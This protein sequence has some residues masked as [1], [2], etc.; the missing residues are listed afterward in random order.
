MLRVATNFY[1]ELFKKEDTPNIRLKDHFFSPREKITPGENLE[2]ERR[3]TKVRLEK[4]SLVLMLKEHKVLMAY[5]SYFFQKFWK[6]IK[7]DLM[8]HFYDW[9]NDRLDIYR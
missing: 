7:E 4:L 2:F 8:E 3:F 5:L 1:K 9:Y 6:I